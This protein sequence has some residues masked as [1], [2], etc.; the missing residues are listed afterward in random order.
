RGLLMR[1]RSIRSLG[2][3]ARRFGRDR[4]GTVAVTGVCFF[5]VAIA[6]V[7][8]VTDWGSMFL[9]KRDQQG[10]TDLAALVAARNLTKASVAA[11]AVIAAN[12]VSPT[13]PV[14][15]VLG[16]YTPDRTVPV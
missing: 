1:A 13:A 11:N 6:L 9:T 2:S 4:S 3:L 16:R 7:A 14:E 8:L 5:L 15:V 10:A 12:G